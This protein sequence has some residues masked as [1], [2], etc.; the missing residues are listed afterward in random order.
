M[1]QPC[2]QIIELL[3]RDVNPKWFH[4]N[5]PL[6]AIASGQLNAQAMSQ[7]VSFGP[8]STDRHGAS[9]PGSI[10]I[11][12]SLNHAPLFTDDNVLCRGFG[13]RAVRLSRP[14]PAAQAHARGGS[15]VPGERTCPAEKWS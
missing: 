5:N 13:R 9:P 3:I 2:P 6:L 8:L 12:R 14:V 10:P 7:G 11:R 15:W 1:L 4:Y